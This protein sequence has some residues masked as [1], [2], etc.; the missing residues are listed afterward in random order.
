MRWLFFCGR[1][2][3]F[4]L[5]CQA[6]SDRRGKFLDL[7]IHYGGSSSDSLAFEASDLCTRLE[8]GLLSDGLV[9]FGDNAYINRTYLATPYPNIG[10]GSKNDYN[11]FHS[12]VSTRKSV[13][14]T[15]KQSICKEHI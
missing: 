7:S 5:N 6:V 9:L 15:E 3:K 12:Q 2:H 1:K 8:S 11:Y 10:G 14:S 13:V 4:G